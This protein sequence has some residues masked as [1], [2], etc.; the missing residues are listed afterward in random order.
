MGVQNLERKVKPLRVDRTCVSIVPH[1]ARCRI[2]RQGFPAATTFAGISLTTTRTAPIVLRSP[3]VTPAQIIQPPPI[4]TL[5]PILI[6]LASSLPES[7]I[8]G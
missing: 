1:Q 2:I 5:L 6:S 4:Q 7:L 3:I 8:S